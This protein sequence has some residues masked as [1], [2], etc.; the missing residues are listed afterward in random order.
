MNPEIILVHKEQWRIDLKEEKDVYS[1]GD[2]P[3]EGVIHIWSKSLRMICMSSQNSSKG[4]YYLMWWFPS[5]SSSIQSIYK[6]SKVERRCFACMSEFSWKEHVFSSIFSTWHACLS[7]TTQ[8]TTLWILVCL[9]FTSEVYFII[10]WI[11]IYLGFVHYSTIACKNNI[12]V[13]KHL[14]ATNT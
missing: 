8:L 14:K 5:S 7:Y 3:V 6:E 13:I 12:Y 4:S 9:G 11:F 1:M 2:F 10:Y